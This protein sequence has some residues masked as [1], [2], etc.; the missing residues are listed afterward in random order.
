MKNSNNIYVV[1]NSSFSVNV[2]ELDEQHQNYFAIVNRIYKALD[3]EEI[4]EELLRILDQLGGYAHYHLATE[5]E[6]FSKFDYTDKTKHI[7]EHNAFREKIQQMTKEY[8]L[9]DKE[10]LL[11]VANFAK[12][13]MMNHILRSDK[14]YSKCFNENGLC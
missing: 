7:Q 1:W 4:G 10:A 9:G 5:E 11:K 12:D 6:Y 8:K 3:S 14:E 2:K 13:W